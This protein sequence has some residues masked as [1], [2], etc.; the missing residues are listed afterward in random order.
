MVE[1]S[2][3]PSFTVHAK[4]AN[5]SIAAD[6][7]DGVPGSTSA[8]MSH[9]TRSSG[10]T[11]GWDCESQKDVSTSHQDPYPPEF[12]VEAIRLIRWSGKSLAQ[13]GREVQVTSE[14]LRQW[15]KQ[16]D[17]DD[18]QRHNGLTTEEHPAGTQVARRVRREVKTSRDET[19]LPRGVLL[20]LQR[21]ATC[22]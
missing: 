5:R 4:G 18:G 6:V 16:E 10:H 22:R 17:R 9:L 21:P 1:C 7:D 8:L 12:H 3:C 15:S 2:T 13:T 14:T 19:D 11:Q 20:L